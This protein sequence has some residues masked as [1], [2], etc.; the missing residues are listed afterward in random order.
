MQPVSSLK[1]VLLFVG[2]AVTGLA[3]QAPQPARSPSRGVRCP[4]EFTAMWDQAA[5]ILRCR[6]DVVSW[7]VTACPDKAFATYLVKSGED[8]CG[9]T[10]IPGVGT[11]PGAKGVKGVACVA[12]GYELMTD[13][14]GDR[15]RCEKVERIFALPLPAS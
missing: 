1:E 9:P 12:P 5:K 13:R 11:P 8:S 4:A 10:E 2:I 15:D 14:T 3:A 7:V 6:R